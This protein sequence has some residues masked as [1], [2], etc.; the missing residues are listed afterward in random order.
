MDTGSFPGVKRPGRGV[1][2]P[3]PSRAEVKEREELYLYSSSGRFWPVIGCT[4]LFFYVHIVYT[5]VQMCLSDTIIDTVRYIITVSVYCYKV[6]KLL[7]GNT[8]QTENI[9]TYIT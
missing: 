4:L 1:N 5:G 2:H 8:L 7:E 3:T 6:F 9:Y